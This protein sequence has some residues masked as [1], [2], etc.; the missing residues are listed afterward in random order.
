MIRELRGYD[1]KPGCR[2][3]G[4]PAQAVTP[5]LFVARTDGGWAI[6]LNA[7]TLPRVLVNR[8]YYAELRARRAGQGVQGVAGR[9]ARRA[10]TGW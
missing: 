8:R 9:D 7:A 10:P 6:E 3:G 2:Y 5:D 1:P 4:E